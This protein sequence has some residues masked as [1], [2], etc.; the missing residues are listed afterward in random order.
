M[1][2]LSFRRTPPVSLP[3][4]DVQASR[5]SIHLA[6]SHAGVTGVHQVIRISHGEGEVVYY[7]DIDAS[8]DL[9]PAQKGVHMS[10]FA[11]LFAEA[12]EQVVIGEALIV[13]ELAEHIA[14]EILLRQNALRS[15][16]RIEARY[17]VE[18]VTPV[19]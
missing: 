4:E 2:R 11:E 18:R 8:V 3:D 19:T 12:I 1:S 10:R 9:D 7:A 17:P 15:H 6:L 13:E 14:R 16:V 5:P